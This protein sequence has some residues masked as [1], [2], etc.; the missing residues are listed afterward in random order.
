MKKEQIIA[1][2]VIVV[3]ALALVLFGRSGEAPLEGTAKIK[4]ALKAREIP[5]LVVTDGNA[6]EQSEFLDSVKAALSGTG[7]VRLIHVD[8][9]NPNE[10]DTIGQFHMHKL[11]Q[12]IVLGLDGN[13]TLAAGT[14]EAEAVQKAVAEGL[15]KKPVPIEEG[16]HHHH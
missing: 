12:V 1:A 11:P 9:Q 5:V 16:H 6:G 15:E 3:V 13:P 4:A 2:G 14:V 7:R 10:R 8:K